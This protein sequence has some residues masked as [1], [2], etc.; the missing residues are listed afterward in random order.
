MK[1][2]SLEID[3]QVFADEFFQM[4]EERYNEGAQEYGP[5]GFINNNMMQFIAEELA[6]VANYALMTYMKIRFMQEVANEG[7]IDLS[8]SPTSED[9]GQNELPPDP[10]PFVSSEAVQQFLP[11]QERRG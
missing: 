10:S 7:G 4:M 3:L 6:D 5:T 1:P 11:D 8:A 2:D 9:G